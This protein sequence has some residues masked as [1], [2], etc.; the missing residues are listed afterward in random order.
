MPGAPA[1]ATPLRLCLYS[2]FLQYRPTHLYR[3]LFTYLLTL[4]VTYIPYLQGSYLHSTDLLPPILRS[5]ILPPLPLRHPHGP[6]SGYVH[7]EVV[8]RKQRMELLRLVHQVHSITG[9][10][11]VAPSN[12]FAAAV[13]STSSYD[14]LRTDVY[15]G[16]YVCA[17]GCGSE[18]L[19][20]T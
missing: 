14:L 15:I 8:H 3:T 10:P 16:Q 6:R 18:R 5:T 11:T 7:G 4:G 13:R 1:R 12:L 20:V 9:V 19:V 2:T 17:P